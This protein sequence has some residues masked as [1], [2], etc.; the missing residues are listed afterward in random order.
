MKSSM[1]VNGCWSVLRSFSSVTTL[2]VRSSDF[3]DNKIV[4]CI[5]KQD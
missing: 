5:P 3:L 2:T 4:E 1:A